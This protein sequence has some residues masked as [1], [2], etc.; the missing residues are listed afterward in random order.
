MCAGSILQFK[1][2]RVVVGQEK[3]E[4]PRAAYFVGQATALAADG[5]EVAM[6]DDPECA[7][8]FA[9]FLSTSWGMESWLGD[10]G[11]QR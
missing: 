11:E 9:E 4:S 3:I 8:L 5:I 7:K 1:I 10:I 2:E 6:L